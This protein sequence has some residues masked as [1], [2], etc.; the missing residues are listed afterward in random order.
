MDCQLI[1]RTA[2]CLTVINGLG[3]ASVQN[4][5]TSLQ[6][7]IL[8]WVSI[9]TVLWDHGVLF[10]A[11]WKGT[12]HWHYPHPV[13]I[14]LEVRIVS[15]LVWL[16]TRPRSSSSSCWNLRWFQW[17]HLH[18]RQHCWCIEITYTWLGDKLTAIW[19]FFHLLL[20]ESVFLQV[21]IPKVEL[22]LASVKVSNTRTVSC[23]NVIVITCSSSFFWRPLVLTLFLPR[24]CTPT[25][26]S[27]YLRT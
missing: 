4:I 3:W 6:A 23:A 20:E 19:M 1:N 13:H 21:G 18:K 25:S 9:C 12:P 16:M 14:P 24:F 22:N 27:I 8:T 17:R 10:T 26:S 7:R 2:G 5:Y 11:A 15:W